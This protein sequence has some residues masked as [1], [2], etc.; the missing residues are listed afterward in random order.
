MRVRRE[1]SSAVD[2]SANGD[3]KAVEELIAARQHV[4][5]Q[6]VG[7]FLMQHRDQI[8]FLV[9]VHDLIV[10]QECDDLALIRQ[11]RVL[12]ALSC[13]NGK[14][15]KP[16]FANVRCFEMDPVLDFA[17]VDAEAAQ[18]DLAI[19]GDAAMELKLPIG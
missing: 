9:G 11:A 2:L 4:V 19:T 16:A 8:L 7:E 13:D 5:V 17:K 10:D 6:M 12:G 15:H 14:I 1:E 18:F 3:G